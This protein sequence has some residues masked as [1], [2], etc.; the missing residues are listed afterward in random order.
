MTGGGP[1]RLPGW[2]LDA[3]RHRFGLLPARPP[4]V[5]HI[6]R[7]RYGWVLDEWARFAAWNSW[8]D[9]GGRSPRPSGLWERVPGWAWQIRRE[10]LHARPSAPSPPPAA[11]AKPAASWTFRQPVVFTAWQPDLARPGPWLT[12]LVDE[13]EGP[14]V[15]WRVPGGWIA[16]AET[17]E[18]QALAVE[19]LRGKQGSRAVV[20]TQ[21]GWTNPGPLLELGVTVCFAEAY[22]VDDPH[23]TPAQVTWQAE[24]DGWPYA[25]PVAGCY[26]GYPLA[27]YDLSAWRP[28]FAVWL[29]E[30]MTDADW[31]TLA[32]LV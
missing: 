30:E 20:A 23:W 24:H 13:Q 4:G 15:A 27:S 9:R 7:D 3:C 2:W 16:Q 22:Q 1:G 29:A 6:T 5:P 14:W 21:A 11:P 25:Y 31:R 28:V 32:T 17:P 8:R 18:Q 12:A 19:Y 10:L 26:H